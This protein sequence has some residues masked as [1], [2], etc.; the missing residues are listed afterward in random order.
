MLTSSLIF[1]LE[2]RHKLCCWVII[3]NFF[4][5]LHSSGQNIRRGLGFDFLSSTLLYRHKLFLVRVV[6]LVNTVS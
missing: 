5:T 6:T 2:Q 4:K 3:N 1:L